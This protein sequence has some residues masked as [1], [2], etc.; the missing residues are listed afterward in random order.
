KRP[1][2]ILIRYA[3]GDFSKTYTALEAALPSSSSI[4]RAYLGFDQRIMVGF[5]LARIV[6]MQGFPTQAIELACRTID[7]AE[8]NS[9]PASLAATLS[10]VASVFIWVGDLRRAEEHVDRLIPQ[11][12]AYSLNPFLHVARAYKGILAIYNG[13]A[14]SGVQTLQDC[15]KLLHAMHFETRTIELNIVLTQ[16]LTAIGRFDEAIA[17]ID[18]TIRR[19]EE[20]GE[21]F[22]LPEALRVKG[23]V[24]L[25]M[26]VPESDAAEAYFTQSLE[27]SRQQG[28]RGWELRTA[29]DLARLLA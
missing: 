25:S 3:M 10:F 14:R 18:E 4:Q 21:L 28:A 12:E 1:L 24:F 20:K 16:G 29:I 23:C 9:V 6:W 13:N 8:Q 19:A 2:S 22:F 27:L 7:E 5:T 17:V 11:A 26:P 15:L